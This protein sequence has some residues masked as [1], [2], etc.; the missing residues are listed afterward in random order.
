MQ[1]EEESDADS[2]DSNATLPLDP[3]DI[4]ETAMSASINNGSTSDSVIECDTCP[5]SVTHESTETPV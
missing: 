4:V 3:I 2:I 5:V 1:L